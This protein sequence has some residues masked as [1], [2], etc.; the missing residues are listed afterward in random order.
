MRCRGV[1]LIGGSTIE[2]VDW[3]FQV[4]AECDGPLDCG[5]EE[6]LTEN[7]GDMAWSI[8]SDEFDAIQARHLAHSRGAS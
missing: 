5:F 1:L 3:Q 4:I 6:H 2:S 7:D 8:T